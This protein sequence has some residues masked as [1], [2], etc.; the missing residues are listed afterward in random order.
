[1]CTIAVH[2]WN[3]VIY[4]ADKNP[5]GKFL[6][7][8]SYHKTYLLMRSKLLLSAHPCFMSA[9][10][11]SGDDPNLLGKLLH[12]WLIEMG[13]SLPGISSNQFKVVNTVSSDG[14]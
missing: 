10:A 3:L 6:I 11:P 7:L 9:I 1:M 8:L 2:G 4:S 12:A 13:N 14:I 5:P